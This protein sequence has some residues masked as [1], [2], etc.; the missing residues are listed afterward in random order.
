MIKKNKLIINIEPIQQLGPDIVKESYEKLLNLISVFSSHYY[1]LSLTKY[2]KKKARV[3]SFSFEV[4]TDKTE[5]EIFPAL[6]QFFNKPGILPH[7]YSE[8]PNQKIIF[9]GDDMGQGSIYTFV[10]RI[11]H[12]PTKLS[13]SLHY[14]FNIKIPKVK[15]AKG[16]S[17]VLKTQ[18]CRVADTEKIDIKVKKSFSKTKNFSC[19]IEYRTGFFP[20]PQIF[21]IAKVLGYKV[22]SCLFK[23]GA[24]NEILPP[25]KFTIEFYHPDLD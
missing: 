25:Q 2:E 18:L 23:Y 21:T 12:I 7:H 20:Y 11:G 14:H 24:E 10:F 15:D 8:Q 13:H 1:D 5:K 16:V 22:K 9:M 3:T 4:V 17:N 19:Q 6:K